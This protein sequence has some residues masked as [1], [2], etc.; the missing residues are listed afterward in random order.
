MYSP[1]KFGQKWD[2]E[3]NFIKHFVPELK[4]Y[5]A[6]YIYEPWNAPLDIQKKAKCIIGTDYP[7]PMLDAEKESLCAR[8]AG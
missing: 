2:K 7:E 6:K 4:D 8:T 1:A 5:P 3:G